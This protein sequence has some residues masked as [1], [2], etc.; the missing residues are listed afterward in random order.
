MQNDEIIWQVIGKHFCSFKA[1]ITTTTFCRNEYNASG[2]CNRGSCP[3]AS[4]QYATVLE[5]EGKVYLYMKTIER[6]HTP[7][8][9]WERVLLSQNYIKA[10]EQI[11]DHLEYWSEGIKH[12]AKLRLTRIRQTLI[13]MRRL[14]LS[15]KKKL[16]PIRTRE[17]RRDRVRE[18]K[19]LIAAAIDKKIKEELKE[20]L[21]KGDLH[22]INIDQRHFNEVMDEV[23]EGQR[24]VIGEEEI[25]EEEDES[26]EEEDDEVTNET[27][28]VEEF[29]ED[30]DDL[31]EYFGEESEEEREEE[32]EISRKRA[33][34]HLLKSDRKKKA[35]IVMEYED[36][37]TAQMEEA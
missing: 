27:E 6:A 35:K 36:E 1:R 37:D 15:L 17:E 28:T 22:N 14:K 13:R 3:L 11:D 25:E 2:L 12:R 33:S 32:D 29:V 18:E 24:D 34:S 16:V 20:R 31:E 23:G 10:L 30:I 21:S 9:L 8:K 7:S 26:E 5:K 19:A 4:S